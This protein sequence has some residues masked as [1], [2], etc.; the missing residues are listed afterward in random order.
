MQRK[1]RVV[2]RIQNE[3]CDYKKVEGGGGEKRV[4][5]YIR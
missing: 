2:N 4:G 5:V 1:R 3:R